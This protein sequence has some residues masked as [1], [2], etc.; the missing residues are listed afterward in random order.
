MENLIVADMGEVNLVAEKYGDTEICIYFQDKKT[1]CVTQDIAT[2]RQA[3]NADEEPLR[4]TVECLVWADEAVESYTH[5]FAITQFAEE[6]VTD[7]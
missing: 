2:V 4:N 1:K 3:T 5:R 7:D 6:D